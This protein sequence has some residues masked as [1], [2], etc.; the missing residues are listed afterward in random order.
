MAIKIDGDINQYIKLVG[1][2]D[3]SVKAEVQH[4]IDE[5]GCT[6]VIREIDKGFTGYGLSKSYW[7]LHDAGVEFHWSNDQLKAVSLY[8]QRGESS[9]SE[10]KPYATPLFAEFSNTATREEIIRYLGTPDNEAKQNSTW[11]H[12]A[13]VQYDEQG[14]NWVHFEF[15]SDMHLKMVTICVPVG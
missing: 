13:W 12:S 15:D 7:L 5:L 1:R 4:I 3:E 10:Y 6:P 14:G 8:T 11:V 2:S 9:V